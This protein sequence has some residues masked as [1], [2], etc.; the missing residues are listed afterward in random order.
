MIIRCNTLKEFL[1]FSEE[2]RAKITWLNLRGKDI[3]NDSAIELS[4]SLEKNSAITVFGLEYSN[5]DIDPKLN[6][7]LEELIDRND[8]IQ[9]IVLDSLKE[10]AK[11]KEVVDIDI[12]KIPYIQHA[13]CIINHIINPLDMYLK[14]DRFFKEKLQYYSLDSE[15][16]DDLCKSLYTSNNSGGGEMAMAEI[17]QEAEQRNEEYEVS[18][19]GEAA[20]F[21]S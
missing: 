8:L 13:E 18:A 12:T 17:E 10:I 6:V 9:K 4:R 1:E 7:F 14:N 15:V 11:G 20:D 19:S 16:L 2:H 5:K 3:D 21:G